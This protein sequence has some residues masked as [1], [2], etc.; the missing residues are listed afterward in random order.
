MRAGQALI[1]LGLAQG[2]S[3]AIPIPK[4]PEVPQPRPIEPEPPTVY[5]PVGPEAP[6]PPGVNPIPKPPSFGSPNDTP[7]G[8]EPS[9][10]SSEQISNQVNPLEQKIENVKDAVDAAQQVVEAFL[11]VSSK[12]PSPT[13]NS[14]AASTTGGGTATTTFRFTPTI[15]LPSTS[16]AACTSYAHI[17]SSCNSATASFYGMRPT[18][19][20]KCACFT[21]AVSERACSGTG[22]QSVLQ[23]TYAPQRF[24]DAAMGC[25]NYFRAQGYKNIVE[26]LDGNDRNQTVLGAGFCANVNQMNGTAHAT[27]TLEGNPLG[28]C[29]LGRQG[30]LRTGG[31]S[32]VSG[33]T[34]FDISV[35]VGFT[36]S[37]FCYA[38]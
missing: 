6:V 22:T 5:N 2:I 17:L 32:R 31:V 24:D 19:Q 13:G 11:D 27:P 36:V 14:V 7:I 26:A 1:F 29:S 35:F 9:V 20:A 4:V 18:D 16:F 21:T 3:A 23:P 30:E 34:I 15:T 25:V 10:P 28:S 38:Y 37:I 12:K 33:F 8:S